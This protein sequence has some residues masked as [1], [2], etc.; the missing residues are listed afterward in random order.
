MEP[1]ENH[2]FKPVKIFDHIDGS[3]RLIQMKVKD[4]FS[5]QILHQNMLRKKFV[6][7]YIVRREMNWLILLPYE[8]E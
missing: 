1:I 5:L 7:N 8:T 6:L 4:N 3:H 2:L